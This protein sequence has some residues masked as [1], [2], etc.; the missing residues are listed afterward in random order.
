MATQGD[1]PTLIIVA[2]WAA[3]ILC[4]QTIYTGATGVVAP[5]FLVHKRIAP[6]RGFGA[7]AMYALV[8]FIPAVGL[9]IVL[10]LAMAHRTPSWSSV[11]IG[12]VLWA[13]VFIVPGLWLV[14]RPETAVTWAQQAHPEF[15]AGSFILTISKVIGAALVL[16][17]ISFALP[18]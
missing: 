5:F 7:R 2:A 17:G 15:E 9:A 8:Y 1:V 11:T 13:L 18:W 10:A 16:I 12:D 3:C 4:V 14:F 6:V